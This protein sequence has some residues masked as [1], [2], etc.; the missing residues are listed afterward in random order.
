[1]SCGVGRGRSSDPT[2]L[3][4]WH[5]PA[6]TVPIGPLAWEPPYARGG[7]PRK[8]QKDQKKKKRNIVLQDSNILLMQ[9]QNGTATLEDSLAVSYKTQHIIRYNPAITHLS[10]YPKELKT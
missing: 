1:M 4:L 5:R 2:L 8:R 9:M 7:G 6:G 10:I 3:Q